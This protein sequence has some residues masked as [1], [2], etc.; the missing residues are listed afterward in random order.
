MKL[1]C[2][3]IACVAGNKYVTPKGFN[4]SLVKT[5]DR[6]RNDDG[7]IR[8]VNQQEFCNLT[9]IRIQFTSPIG[10]VIREIKPEKLEK[11]LEK[12]NEIL[13]LVSK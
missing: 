10:E 4:K 9:G 5:V 6:V 2:G 1:V 11:T 8:M 13:D 7:L 12:K 3:H